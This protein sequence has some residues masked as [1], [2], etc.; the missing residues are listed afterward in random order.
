MSYT[1]DQSF[2]RIAGGLKATIGLA[3]LEVSAEINFEI[4]SSESNSDLRMAVASEAYGFIEKEPLTF[5]TKVQ[6]GL[7]PSEQIEMSIAAN[8]EAFIFKFCGFKNTKV[9]RPLLEG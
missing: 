8:I 6:N 2:D 4:A 5:P 9:N 3:V 7:S 1:S